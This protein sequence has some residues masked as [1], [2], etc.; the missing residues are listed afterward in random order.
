MPNRPAL[1]HPR[2]L[3]SLRAQFY[4]STLAIEAGDGAQDPNSGEVVNGW[5]VVSGM[6]A[7]PAVVA[8]STV[9]SVTATEFRGNFETVVTE[10]WQISLN[11]RWPAI[12]PEMRAHMDDG[13]IF[14]ILGVEEDSHLQ[15]TRLK[16]ERKR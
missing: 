12:T 2:M 15:I 7:I 3:S 11:G 9:Q 16:A 8:P 13:R 4:P 1:A 5:A 10:I 14:N 6:E